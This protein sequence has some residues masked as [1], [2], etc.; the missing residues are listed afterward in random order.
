MEEALNNACNGTYSSL[1]CTFGLS[2]VTGMTI[3]SVYPEK[4]DQ[5]T[6]YSQFLNGKILPRQAHQH[7]SSQLVQPAKLILMWTTTGAYSLPELDIEFQPNHFV[8][9]IEFNQTN[10]SRVNNKKKITDHFKVD[11]LQK[12]KSGL[13]Q[14]ID[15]TLVAP[16]KSSP[17]E[18]SDGSSYDCLKT[19]LKRPLSCDFE[20]GKVSNASCPLSKSVKTDMTDVDPLDIGHFV[21]VAALDD[22]TKLR[23]ITNHWK[24][25]PSFNFPFSENDKSSRKFC[26]GWLD[27]WSWL[28]YS[29]LFDGAFCYY[30]VLFGHQTGHNGSKLSK[31]FKEPLRN[32]QSTAT[33]FYQH[34]KYSLIH[35]DSKL[36]LSQFRSS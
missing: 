26:A 17:R 16:A 3:I 30:C 20:D 1:M 33:K 10:N 9:L 32:W 21:S 25:P 31:L 13:E 34:D 4:L 36:R 18:D 27:R 15:T 23:L 28:C 11:V 19:S 2:S 7:I 35:R 8:P 12:N 24:P 5:E 6:K 29:K 22:D 14:Q